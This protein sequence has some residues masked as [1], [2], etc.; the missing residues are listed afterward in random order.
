MNTNTSYSIAG[1]LVIGSA[2][3]LTVFIMYIMT[4][5]MSNMTVITDHGDYKIVDAR[6]V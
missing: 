3:F 1:K 6:T 4:S 5:A 2:L